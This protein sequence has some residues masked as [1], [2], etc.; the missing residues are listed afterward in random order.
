MSNHKSSSDTEQKLLSLI[1]V[2]VQLC[3]YEIDF[4]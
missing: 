1:V 2:D 4:I 3:K